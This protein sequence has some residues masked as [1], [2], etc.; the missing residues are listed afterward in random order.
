MPWTTKEDALNGEFQFPDF[1]TAFAFMT[2]VA[3]AAES[4]GHHPE[5]SNVYNRVNI[6]LTTHDAGNTITDKDHSLAAAIAKI[7]EKY[8]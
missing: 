2:E 7:Y 5:W 4:A 8:A 6:R 1:T 3:F